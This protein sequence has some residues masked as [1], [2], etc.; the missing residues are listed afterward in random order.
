MV[1]FGDDRVRWTLR[2]LT[3]RAFLHTTL[4]AAG[5]VLVGCTDD[6]PGPDDGPTP[7]ATAPPPPV[8]VDDA[9]ELME[10][11]LDEVRR[12]P[13][14]REARFADLVEAGDPAALL[15]WVR[16][17]IRT[18]PTTRDGFLSV[19]TAGR[20][21]PRGTLRAGLGTPRDVA[22][23]LASGLTG[24]GLAATV[25]G[26]TPDPVRDL[27]SVRTPPFAF[28]ERL[29]AAAA[30]L[31][32]GAPL[33]PAPIDVDLVRGTAERV[34]ATVPDLTNRLVAEPRA[35]PDVAVEDLDG[36]GPALARIWTTDG[37][38]EA[39]DRLP[40]ALDPAVRPDVTV[41]LLVAAL[42]DEEAVPVA[43]LTV[44]LEEAMGRQVRISTAPAVDAPADLLGTPPATVTTFLP[45]LR[46][47]GVADAVATGDPITVMGDRLVED[48]DG[49][50]TG[51]GTVVAGGDGADATDV[52][53]T[54]VDASTFPQ[55]T[56]AVRVVGVADPVGA[57]GFV[58]TDGGGPV[59][60][61]LRSNTGVRRRVLFLTDTSTSV[62]PAYRGN[63]AGDVARA[64]A[65]A[66]LAAG[67]PVEFRAAGI[68]RADAR[69][70]GPWTTDPDELAR[71]ASRTAFGSTMWE[72][73]AAADRRFSP[74]VIVLLTDGVAFAADDRTPQPT[75]P[76][77]VV[78]ALRAAAPAVVL[79]AGDLGE[80]FEGIPA[81]AGG[82]AVAVEDQQ[83]GIDAVLTALAALPP[84]ADHVLGVRVP[85]ARDRAGEVTVA[86]G[87]ARA[88]AQYLPPPADQV[89]DRD[90]LAQLAVEVES[91]G[92]VVRRV[93]AGLPLRRD[94]LVDRASAGPH[95]LTDVRRGLF[96]SYTLTIDG[97]AP[98][99]A[100]QLEQV[101]TGRLSLR[102]VIEASSDEDLDAAL[103]QLAVPSRHALAFSGPLVGD[104]DVHETAFRAWLDVDRPAVD[105]DG[106]EVRLQAVDLLPFTTFD[107]ASQD[108][109][110]RRVAHA[111]MTLAVLEAALL[112]GDDASVGPTGEFVAGPL[113]DLDLRQR[114]DAAW[115][116]GWVYVGPQQEDVDA[117][118]DELFAIER[119]TG[120][121]VSVLV[122]G[123]QGGRV[124]VQQVERTFDAIDSVLELAGVV[125]GIPTSITLW[126]SLE[127]AKIRKLRIATIAILT[128][129]TG[130][131]R[132]PTDTGFGDWACDVANDLG[133]R[134]VGAAGRRAFGEA[135]DAAIGAA[136]RWNAT[137]GRFFGT[138]DIR[139]GSSSAEPADLCTVR[140]APSSHVPR[141][142]CP[143][144]SSTSPQTGTRRSR[145]PWRCCAT[146]SWSWSRPTRCTAS[147]PTR[148]T[149]PGRGGS[150]GPSV[151]RGGSRCRCSC[152][153]RSSCS[154]CARRSP[155]RPSD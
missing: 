45:T 82:T 16:S 29:L 126:A 36:Q 31:G 104:G 80:A 146:A 17:S 139:P 42:D 151:A 135:F 38:F 25:V 22:D 78:A 62:P 14:H 148:S 6:D 19:A 72:S 119:G 30:D 47:V 145:V 137:G 153:H 101:L 81:L 57:E 12:S 4:L 46:L 9:W 98:S 120:S 99:L 114:L 34:L 35:L 24:M 134:V 58:V 79:G 110:V 44:P 89:P 65:S 43:E 128:M 74:D 123:G 144:G 21:G 133:G 1:R 154:G 131:F 59:P 109:P 69:A 106:A 91:M 149:A 124:T 115:P 150:S 7:T 33:A 105:Q 121:V 87:D 122:P 26:G 85:E 102:P 93:L 118:V 132:P 138:P 23:L 90:G 103:A 88:T 113:A 92:L 129:G 155:R 112:D 40:R 53:I 55:L 86:V 39:V 125:D 136:D 130:E 95:T 94:R 127:R 18:M 61:L 84:A 49:L 140:R 67:E 37:G 76:D 71:Q 75:P 52:E 143:A 2:P 83:E 141:P 56:V 111:S 117:P 41:R 116:G 70:Q 107:T 32:G 13:D 63:G 15:D 5:G 152:G 27:V 48:G 3:R 147:P 64:V 68:D 60:F 97:G 11:A 77:E 10:L 54:N 100:Q 8:E 73:Y 20:W 50:V 28:D 142:R 66:L 96:G 108:D 51:A